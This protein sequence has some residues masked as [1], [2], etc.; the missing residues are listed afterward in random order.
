LNKRIKDTDYLAISARIRAMEN[1]LLTQPRM[2]KILDARREEE[3]TK[4]LQDCNYFSGQ[5]NPSE[6]A[7]MDAA[8]TLVRGR[9]FND[10]LSGAPD[11]RYVDIFRMKYDY[12]NLK[13]LLKGKAL[14][15]NVDK[16]L[17]DI[18]RVPLTVLKEAVESEEISLL[19]TCLGDALLETKE[20]LNTTRDP[21]LS[22]VLLD[23]WYYRDLTVLAEEI[24]SPFVQG[25]IRT[26]IDSVNLR[27]L[28]RTI[29]MGKNVEFLKGTLVD[30]GNVDLTTLLKIGADRGAGLAEAYHSTDLKEAA[31]EGASILKTGSMTQFE[32]LCDD[33]VA[34]YMAV[35]QTVSFGEEPLLAY[36]SAH[37]TEFINLRILLMG[38]MTGLSDDLI[39]S[40]LRTMYI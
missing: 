11:K 27:I 17:M 40:R 34:G 14:G 39:R 16:I 36:M 7:E 37:E 30:G 29:R 38:R 6:P 26:R 32:K 35:A 21:Q 9:M 23:R 8:L 31:Q 33:G 20:V 10:M 22:D 18:G 19:P 2:E 4:I 3:I 12:H 24:G 15:K 28:V 13:A 1:M 25:Y 5:F